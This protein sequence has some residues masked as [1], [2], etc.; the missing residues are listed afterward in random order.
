MKSSVIRAF[1]SV[2]GMSLLVSGCSEHEVTTAP[3][4]KQAPGH[5]T[6]SMSAL[7]SF[8]GLFFLAIWICLA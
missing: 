7:E 3:Q 8:F 1:G 2:I 5:A 6:P 4:V